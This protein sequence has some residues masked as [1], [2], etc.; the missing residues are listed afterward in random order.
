MSAVTRGGTNAPDD[1]RQSADDRIVWKSQYAK[2]RR[3]GTTHPSRRPRVHRLVRTAIRF[4]ND[5]PRK[6]NEIREKGPDRRL[7]TKAIPVD[8]MISQRAPK[9]RF[10]PRHIGTLS[11]RELARRLRKTRRLVHLRSTSQSWR[12]PFSS[13]AGEGGRRPDGVWPAA[14]TQV[15]LHDRRGELA[16]SHPGFPHPI[17]RYAPLSPLR[18]E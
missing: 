4:D 8:L 11:P 6:T 9:H 15:G 1:D 2:K 14:S 18:G 13:R 10:R 17:R 5:F 12:D 7:S 16:S 3:A